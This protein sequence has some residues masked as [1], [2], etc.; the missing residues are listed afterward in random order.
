MLT[1]TLQ[2]KLVQHT[3][4]FLDTEETTVDFVLMGGSMGSEADTIAKNSSVAGV[5]NTRKDCIAFISP[6]TG[7]Q[8]ATSGGTALTPA[9]QLS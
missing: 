7:N 9:Q 1:V 4:L 3:H 5:A 2:E 8:V 6:Y